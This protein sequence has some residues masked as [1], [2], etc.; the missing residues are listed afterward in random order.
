MSKLVWVP[1]PN[2]PNRKILSTNS[3]PTFDVPVTGSLPFFTILYRYRNRYFRYQYR[4]CIGWHRAHSY[5]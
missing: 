3:V 4:L 5:P 2:L 1:V